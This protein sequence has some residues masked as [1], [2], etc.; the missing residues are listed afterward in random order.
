MYAFK[1]IQDAITVDGTAYFLLDN[2]RT[3]TMRFKLT[4]KKLRRKEQKDFV[5]PLIDLKKETGERDVLE[6][7]EDYE[8]Y[9]D[10][11][12]RD[13]IVDWDLV[14]A[15]DERVEFSQ[16]ALEAILDYREYRD[17]FWECIEKVQRG[18]DGL[19]RK[20]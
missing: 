19:K 10:Q 18:Y 6:L 20:N 11:V 1:G 7:N 14:D 9:R 4:V 17:A 5:Q 2:G 3:L 13:V 16:N 15:N 8:E 12:F